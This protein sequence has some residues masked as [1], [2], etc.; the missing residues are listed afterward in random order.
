M[1]GR[2]VR[3][4]EGRTPVSSQGVLESPFQTS[5][6]WTERWKLGWGG[7]RGEKGFLGSLLLLWVVG[8]GLDVCGVR[9]FNRNDREEGR[10]RGFG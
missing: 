3:G 8:I 9:G 6:E 4:G 2:G 5:R 7:D 10:V 1:E